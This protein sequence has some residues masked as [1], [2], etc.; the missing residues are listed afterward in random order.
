MEKVQSNETKFDIIKLLKEEQ[1]DTKPNVAKFLQ[2]HVKNIKAVISNGKV[3]F[4]PSAKYQVSKVF[5]TFLDGHEL[6]F[7]AT[8]V[9]PT[10]PRYYLYDG[11]DEIELKQCNVPFV[12]A[13]FDALTKFKFVRLGESD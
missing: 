7:Y 10:L 12:E 13:F 9:I 2:S 6:I 5:V 3:Q 11:V 8:Q 1:L 4:W